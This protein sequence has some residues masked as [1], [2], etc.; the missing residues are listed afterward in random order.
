MSPGV[1]TATVAQIEKD[2]LPLARVTLFL[3]RTAARLAT[4]VGCLLEPQ[5]R[6]DVRGQ[7]DNCAIDTFN[8]LVPAGRLVL[9]SRS[10]TPILTLMI[11]VSGHGMDG[12]PAE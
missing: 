4:Q 10:R 9:R 6:R 7:F 8:I 12:V 5:D 1:D 3:E 2:H 11:G